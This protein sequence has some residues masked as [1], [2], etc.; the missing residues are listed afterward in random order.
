MFNAENL[1]D[2]V[3]STAY[4][5]SGDKVGSVDQ[6][7]LDDRTDEPTWASVTTGL[8]GMS[9]SLAPL[10]GARFEDGALHLAHDKSKIKDAPRVE[11]DRHLSPQEED[12]LYRYYGM[13]FADASNAE[14]TESHTD[15]G[16]DIEDS[17]SVTRSE[18][19]LKVGTEQVEVG[20]AR[21]RK[22]VTTEEQSVTVPVRQ[23]RL[24][25]TRED[26]GERSGGRIEDSGEVVE[27]V[28]L[29]EERPVVDKE[30]V[31]VE[32]VTVGK[33]TV[34]DEQTV[35]EQVRKEQVEVDGD[36]AERR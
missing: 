15:G 20:R 18:E 17:A 35:T 21:L 7:Y 33:E 4:D 30:T 36:D 23:E 28:V 2:V 12:E 3:G 8:F 22:Y 19:R 14:F 24:E 26:I 13:D 10:Q 16:V 31:D 27:E 5:A 34:T 29:R 25:V 32:R 1:N 9:Q 11:A 6:I